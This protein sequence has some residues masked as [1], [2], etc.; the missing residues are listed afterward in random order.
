MTFSWQKVPDPKQSYTLHLE[1]FTATST[2]TGPTGGRDA[3]TVTLSPL[4]T[5]E[6]T[7]LMP[8][9]QA[10]APNVTT[11]K[12]LVRNKTYKWKVRRHQ[13]RCRAANWSTL[14]SFTVK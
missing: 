3:V 7:V 8:S 6:Q 2:I 11:V 1:T 14:G 10:S 4:G 12:S 5:T 9:S 13:L